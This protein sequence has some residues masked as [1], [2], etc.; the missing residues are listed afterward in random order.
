MSTAEAAANSSRTRTDRTNGTAQLLQALQRMRDGDFSVRLPGDWTGLEGKVAD[1]FNEIV[2][3]NARMAEELERV[4][5]I[6]GKEGKT[7]RRAKFDRQPGAW[8]EME[9]SVNT[10]IDDL[11]WPTSEVTRVV[12]KFGFP[13]A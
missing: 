9:T 2:A 5:L 10:L 7:R 1:T 12:S 4:G 8:G 6:V 13:P 3:S 11:L